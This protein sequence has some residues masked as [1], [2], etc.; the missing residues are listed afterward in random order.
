M[1]LQ[2]R[3][4]NYSKYQRSLILFALVVRSY[5]VLNPKMEPVY[6]GTTTCNAQLASGRACTNK[7]YFSADAGYYC[8]V[9][10]KKYEN[11]CQLPKDTHTKQRKNV[12]NETRTQAA[13]NAKRINN[14]CGALGNVSCRKMKM[15]KE[16]QHI[17][18]YYSIFPNFKHGN[19]KDGIGMPQLSPMSLGP[20]DHG[21]PGLPI[22]LNLEN[23]WQSS[24]F[25]EGQS[26]EEFRETQR[27][28]FMD[29]EPHRHNKKGVKPLG[30]VWT[31]DEGTATL[32]SYVEAR[33]FYCTFYQRL[34]KAT[35]QWQELVELV[36]GGGNVNILGYDGVDIDNPSA[37]QLEAL[38]LDDQQPF[39]HEL[40]LVTMLML[41]EE[42]YPWNIHRTVDF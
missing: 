25:Y 7:A 26:E 22:A 1:R 29:A 27:T 30:W 15:M 21:Q 6:Y 36:E 31:N 28:W 37:E 20:V 34:A 10:A 4:I 38:Y 11:A 42:D 14:E 12:E 9:H 17:D 13:E 2:R 8:G 5:D 3:S 16:P 41:W 24:K 18:G 19:R 35:Q 32:Y 40:V 33:Q 39:G 23:F